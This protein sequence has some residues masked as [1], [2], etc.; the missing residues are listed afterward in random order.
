M[1]NSQIQRNSPLEFE[2]HSEILRPNSPKQS[3]QMKQKM[4]TLIKGFSES[5]KTVSKGHLS[6]C[7]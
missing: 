2:H 3:H 1:K 5:N 4:P 7:S 6:D